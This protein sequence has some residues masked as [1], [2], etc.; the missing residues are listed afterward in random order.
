MKVTRATAS[1]LQA[2]M[3]ALAW[4]AAWAVTAQAGMIFSHNGAVDPTTEGWEH[5]VGSGGGTSSG[6]VYND[7]GLG[8]D[9]WFVKDTSADLYTTEGYLQQPTAGQLS[10]VLSNGWTLSATLRVLEHS[11]GYYTAGL[12]TTF[13]DGANDWVMWFDMQADGD[14]IVWFDVGP[15]GDPAYVLEGAG[16]TYHTYSLV[17]DPVSGSAD[18]FVDGVERVSNHIGAASDEVNVQWGAGASN[19]T[20]L[21][22]FNAVSFS[23][24]P[25]PTSLV[26]FAGLGIIGLVAAR[27]RKRAA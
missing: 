10:A 15:N 8:I 12:Y 25:E 22:H 26:M 23:A 11:T 18:L 1:L 5:Y 19:A 3:I 7:L 4:V 20:A 9:A 16:S 21:G 6:P 2:W 13:R 14:P 17:Y 24:V 27:M